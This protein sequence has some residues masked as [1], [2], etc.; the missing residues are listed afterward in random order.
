M[1]VSEWDKHAPFLDLRRFK[2]LVGGDPI[3]ARFMGKDFFQFRPQMKLFVVLNQM[4]VISNLD[5]A[6]RRRFHVIRTGGAVENPDYMLGEK[7]RAEYPGI[8]HKLIGAARRAFG[9]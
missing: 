6:A 4:P 8:L 1:T 2:S 3:D 9:E 5:E 7:L